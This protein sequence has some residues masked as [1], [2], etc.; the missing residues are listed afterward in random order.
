[1]TETFPKMKFY[2]EFEIK[3]RNNQL[4]RYSNNK[5]MGKYGKIF[6]RYDAIESVPKQSRLQYINVTKLA[7]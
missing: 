4:N 7:P 2:A 6:F 1:M 5:I 3:S